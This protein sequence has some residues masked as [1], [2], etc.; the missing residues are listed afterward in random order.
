MST[1]QISSV[2]VEGNVE[3]SLGFSSERAADSGSHRTIVAV[4]L[5]AG[6]EVSKTLA[7]ITSIQSLIAE[8]HGPVTVEKIMIKVSGRKSGDGV[9]FVLSR[10]GGAITEKNFLLKLNA[11]KMTFTSYNVGT[12]LEYDV[13]IPSGLARQISPVSGQFPGLDLFV[14][15]YGEADIVVF[16]ELGIHGDRFVTSAGF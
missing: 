7:S 16:F 14:K 8:I 9:G 13:P 4:P 11:R 12:M 15:S 10:T 1:A 2:Q 3:R 6:T 5:A